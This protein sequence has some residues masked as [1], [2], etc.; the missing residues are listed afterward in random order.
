MKFYKVIALATIAT[1]LLT[2]CATTSDS[3]A[4]NS[5]VEKKQNPDKAFID[6]LSNTVIKVTAYPAKQ[7][8]VNKKF[9]SDYSLSVCDKSG[10]PLAN[11]VITAEYPASKTDG[12]INFEKQNITTD[13]TGKAV[14]TPQIPSFAAD[15]NVYFYS[16]TDSTNKDTINAA[17]QAGAQA[18][19]KVRS[20]IVTKGA[21]L[22]I[23]DYNEKGKPVNNSYEILSEFRTRG[24]TMTGNAPVNETAYIGKP[25]NWL[26][27]QNHEIVENSYGYLI[28]GTIQYVKPVEQAEDGWFCSLTADIS[29]ADMKNGTQVFTGTFTNEVT[30]ANWSKATGKCKEEL[31]KKIVDAIIYGL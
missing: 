25:L 15:T 28:V 7:T 19:W 4:K 30:G 22:F 20:D 5:G 13:E 11:F 24:M 16:A 3:A 17:K 8:N 2:G 1:S 18:A 27:K 31:A 10:Q 26:Y 14:F 9:S 29:V 23:W 21:I 6:S 12:V